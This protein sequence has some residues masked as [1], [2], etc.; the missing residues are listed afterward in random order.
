VNRLDRLFAIITCLQA[1]PRTRA[2][3]LAR[4]FEVSKRTIYRDVAALSEAG[5]PVVSLPGV[6]YRLAEGYFLPPLLLTTPEATALVLGARLLASQTGG[7]VPA[8]AEQAIAKIA[9]VLP[10][11]DRRRLDELGETV[12]FVTPDPAR[13]RHDLETPRLVALRRAILERRVVR[14][15]YH[16]RG[17]DETIARAVE[18]RELAY[19]EGV[20]Y[21]VGHCRLRDGERAFR[22]DR[23]DALVPTDET[24]APRAEPAAATA[25]RP[26]TVR[27]RFAPRAVRWVRERQ[28]W[29]FLREEA[30]TDRAEPV[31]IYA[32]QDLD[33]IAPWLLGWGTAAEAL[34]PELLRHRLR[35]EARALAELLT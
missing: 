7:V 2:E 3:D 33:E 20:W 31:F 4:A 19:G 23:I 22:L 29:S 27:V 35:N 34:A 24:W 6:G 1:R 21:L 9:A 25:H 10:T 5:V 18:P 13:P 8:A 32:P 28:H 15:R 14:L 11:A 26:I 16:G 12:R 30:E 17:R